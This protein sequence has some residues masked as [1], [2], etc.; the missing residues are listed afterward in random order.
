MS[1]PKE[2][3]ITFKPGSKIGR[4]VVAAGLCPTCKEPMRGRMEI[5]GFSPYAIPCRHVLKDQVTAEP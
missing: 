1:K 3:D 5:E 4:Y 2:P